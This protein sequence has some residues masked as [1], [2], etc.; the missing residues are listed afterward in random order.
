ML[1]YQSLPIWCSTSRLACSAGGPVG[2]GGA[3]TPIAEGVRM[4]P[5]DDLHVPRRR[6]LVHVV[7]QSWR[8][9]QVGCRPPLV[10]RVRRIQRVLVVQ[11]GGIVELRFV[12]SG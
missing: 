2:H 8:D 6:E 1:A 12:R 3:R 11:R 9:A 4:E 5:A 10:L 7:V